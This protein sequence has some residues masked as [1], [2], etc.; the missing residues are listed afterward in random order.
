PGAIVVAV[1][2]AFVLTRALT[3]RWFGTEAPGDAFDQA[4]ADIP[5]CALDADG[6]GEQKARYGRLARS[7][8][9]VQREI[10]AVVIEFDHDRDPETLE[11]T[12]AVE[13]ECCPFLR[14]AFDPQRRR[15]RVTVADR[16]MLPA[17][18]A[19][20]HGFEAAQP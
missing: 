12:L 1:R 6:R 14:F 10:E 9:G 3:A 19:I 5:A 20:A 7:A 11:E 8:T 17:L 16:D 13:R 18:D 2:D 4:L 15:L